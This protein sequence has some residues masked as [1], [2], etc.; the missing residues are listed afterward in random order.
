MKR[1]H[2]V[3]GKDTMSEG[4]ATPQTNESKRVSAQLRVTQEALRESEARY[5]SITEMS[6]DWY[7]EQ[8]EN[9][10]FTN[11][12]S[13]TFGSTGVP[14]KLF[15]GVSHADVGAQSMSA[16]AWQEHKALLDAHQAF[17]DVE[18][19][20]VSPTGKMFWLSV[21]GRPIFDEDGCFCGYRGVGKDITARKSA[22]EHL[23]RLARARKV[24]VECNRALVRATDEEN[25]F[26][27]M[28][29]IV[30]ET[31]GY[32]AASVG[33][34][35]HDED[36][37]IELVASSGDHLSY[38]ASAKLSWADN[39]FGDGPA[40]RAV[41]LATPQAI[42]HVDVNP[43]GDMWR[44]I[45]L[46]CG[47]RA[48]AAFP[49]K[50]EGETLG[51]LCIVTSESE[52]FDADEM[53]LLGELADDIAFGVHTLTARAARQRSEAA[54]GASELR[55]QAT[56]EQ[57]VIGIIHADLNGGF[58]RA[59]DKV[60]EI[61]G[62]TREEMLRQNVGSIT[63]PND[64]PN[65]Y[66]K[67]ELLKCGDITSNQSQRRYLKKDGTVI[68]VALNVSLAKTSDGEDP[69][70]IAVLQD[71]T[72]AKHA[73]QMVRLHAM[74]QSLVATFGQQALASTNQDE[75]LSLAAVV[76][77]EGLDVEFYDVL[78]FAPDGQSLILKAGEGW[79]HVWIGQN[80]TEIGLGEQIRFVLDEK[81]PVFVENLK[82]ETRFA[83]SP[84][85]T[86]H[87]ITTS[88]EVMI[89]GT[90]EPFGMLGAYS[91]E[92][93]FFTPESV[94]FF[95]SVAI[96]LETAVERKRADEKFSYLAQF[97]S[98]T[99][100][101]NRNLFRDRLA[102]TL[103]LSMRN[104]WQ[105]GVMFIDLDHFKAVNDTFGHAVGDELLRQVAKRL[106]ECI[107]TSDTVA[108][109]GGDEFAVVLSKMAK[110]DDAGI[111]AQKVITALETV[112]N[113]NGHDAYISASIG[114]AICPVDGNTPDALLK[115][116]DTA[117]YRAK[118][119]GR[120]NY[121]FYLP[122]MNDRVAEQLQLETQLR[123]A[124]ERKEF[125]LYYQ[126]K[127]NIASGEI[128]GFEGLIRWKHP[129]RGLVPPLEFIPLLEETGLIEQVGEWVIRT[130]C[131]QIMHWQVQGIKPRPIAVNLSSRQFHQKNLDVIIS[132]IIKS[133]GVDPKML[134][135]E[136]TESL[137]MSDAPEAIRTLNSLKAFEVGLS[138]DDFGTG[139]SSLA[140]LKKFPVD[141]LK[142]DRVFI[143]D[144]ATNPDD[145]TI[146]MTIISLAHN[147]K[148][149]V[150]A[151]GIENEA[152]LN[153]LRSQGCD[154]FQGFYFSKPLP[155]DDCN[156]MLIEN[157]RLQSTQSLESDNAPAILLV[158]DN[159]DDL[160]ILKQKLAPVGYQVMTVNS[161]EAA[162]EILA[163][164]CF[165]MV[166]CDHNMPK[167]K[168]VEFLSHVR[169]LYPHIVRM[170]VSGVAT[171]DVVS[172]ALN[173]AGINKY[174]TKD[175]DVAEIRTV[176]RQAYESVKRS[177]ESV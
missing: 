47:Y 69:Y 82:S 63:H 86:K 144:C 78:Q 81:E 134:E 177:N 111:V 131:E 48:V 145:A 138:V 150:V 162:F 113:L 87:N 24:M 136:L 143:N 92:Q 163:K 172:D 142:I 53:E 36:H 171:L 170:M 29:Q 137:L 54:L 88:V 140:Y 80:L 20:S 25:L 76:V 65:S 129:T 12:S 165:Q 107:R 45:T 125:V 72:E 68:W 109:L 94:N 31:G 14:S 127:V 79:E 32:C 105:S 67:L 153:F 99:G 43:D 77:A 37:S 97:D 119:Q 173:E 52:A 38:F 23:R 41:R 59:N 156:K 40:G 123:G 34:K 60:C 154:E 121:Q 103:T 27:N 58:V 98:L 6:S 112:F 159:E 75:L 114:I 30:V 133:T 18:F 19:H 13:E 141:V 151:E 139:Y 100:L 91:Q 7:W 93:R 132:D 104:E 17:Y 84:I 8:D 115:N 117:M 39:P 90:S 74:Q 174:L 26:L 51:V 66:E 70:L 83:V 3:T 161:P 166:I 16:P 10:R 176:V 61:F 164:H 62:Y 130:A 85:L 50:A 160:E 56:F 124:L 89:G 4:L 9:L 128:C 155:I 28:C 101:P 35:R 22:E 122:K 106:E 118:E 149:K 157:R 110:A 57:A 120:N 152:Q 146:A 175:L 46:Q 95:Q 55:F 73:E 96:I 168:G 167:M 148:L 158:D 21:S 108:R 49:I 11:F 126:P 2:E 64:Y 5:Q 42:R 116:A 33:L 147:L 1:L 71:I 135:L 44:T 15:L 102:Q 169:T